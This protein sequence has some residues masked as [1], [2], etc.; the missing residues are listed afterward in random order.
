MYKC[1]YQLLDEASS[2]DFWEYMRSGE[3]T[4]YVDVVGEMTQSQLHGMH[5]K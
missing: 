1:M 5:T 4:E 2:L 3:T